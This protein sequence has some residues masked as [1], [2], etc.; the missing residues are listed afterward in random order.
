M[1]VMR[2]ASF[3]LANFAFP[4]G[5]SRRPG[6]QQ[7][8]AAPPPPLPASWTFQPRRP[9]QVTSACTQTSAAA[10]S[11]GARP[12]ATAAAA[13][14]VAAA[15]LGCQCT[16]S[17]TSASVAAAAAPY[18]PAPVPPKTPDKRFL[19][20]RLRDSCRYRIRRHRSA[21]GLARRG[22][23]TGAEGLF[24]SNRRVGGDL[25]PF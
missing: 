24:L 2:R 8:P 14:V 21:P 5:V 13:V 18:C 23:S 1:Q 16:E 22:A 19:L 6:P 15:M 7:A 17:A 9:V 12:A 20:G 25:S 4:T 3:S 10:A 11:S